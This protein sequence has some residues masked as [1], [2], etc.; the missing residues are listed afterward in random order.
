MNNIKY[1]GNKDLSE[2]KTAHNHMLKDI[3]SIEPGMKVVELG[4]GPGFFWTIHDLN[5]PDDSTVILSDISEDILYETEA[6]LMN[7]NHNFS[8][9]KIDAMN[10]SYPD[11]YFDI[12][13]ANHVLYHVEDIYIALSEIKRILKP[14]GTFYSSTL[15]KNNFIE[16]EE[17]FL[18]Y[19]ADFSEKFNFHKR[20]F[21]MDNGREIL[22]KYFSSVDIYRFEDKKEIPDFNSLYDYYLFSG[23]LSEEEIQNKKFYNFLMSYFNKEGKIFI[24]KDSGLFVS[25]NL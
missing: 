12:V 13:I 8:F 19:N 3:L 10:I 23:Y 15:G 7:M 21:L 9:E 25:V 22:E 14:G 2:L 1:I 17:I 4:T 18:K 6:N 24:T 5:I 20:K 11:D 16:L